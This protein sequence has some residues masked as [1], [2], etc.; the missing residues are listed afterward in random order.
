MIPVLDLEDLY[1]L[2]REK[3]KL[4]TDKAPDELRTMGEYDLFTLSYLLGKNSKAY[5][6]LLEC[7]NGRLCPIELIGPSHLRFTW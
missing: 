4:Y 1:P 7:E 3:L 5:Y 2:L 6:Y